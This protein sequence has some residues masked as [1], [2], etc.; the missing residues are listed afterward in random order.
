MNRPDRPRLIQVQSRR[1]LGKNMC[2]ITFSGPELAKEIEQHGYDWI[3]EEADAR[4][5]D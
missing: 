2:R 3:K 1:M 5:D 4:Y